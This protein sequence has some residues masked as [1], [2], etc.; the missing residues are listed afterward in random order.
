MHSLQVYVKLESTEILEV[1]FFLFISS[2]SCHKDIV[3]ITEY[4][5]NVLVLQIL[6]SRNWPGGLGTVRGNVVE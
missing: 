5:F 2:D 4:F 1:S 6:K 3:K